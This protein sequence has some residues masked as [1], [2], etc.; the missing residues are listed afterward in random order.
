MKK[1]S[2]ERIDALVDELR[3]VCGT[4]PA[5]E[6]Y[7]MV[8]HPAFRVGKKPFVIAGM[9]QHTDGATVS[10]NLGPQMQDQLLDDPRFT[11]TPYIGQHGWVTIARD[12]MEKNELLALVSGSWR[13]VAN[14]T[15]LALMDG[16]AK[17]PAK[18]AAVAKGKPAPKPTRRE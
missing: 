6:E 17:P 16:G 4:L 9:N 13:R 14:K 7:V 10:I 8:H 2:G 15:Q 11:R 12:Q 3:A 18:K 5:S 1:N